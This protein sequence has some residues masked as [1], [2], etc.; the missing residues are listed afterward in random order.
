MVT[1]SIE[2]TTIKSSFLSSVIVIKANVY[3]Y[4]F[5]YW[6]VKPNTL[7][8][9]NRG[10]F[11]FLSLWLDQPY[12]IIVSI[13]NRDSN[14]LKKMRFPSVMKRKR[15]RKLYGCYD[16]GEQSIDLF[17]EIYVLRLEKDLKF[18]SR[19]S[20]SRWKFDLILYEFMYLY[21]GNGIVLFN[22]ALHHIV[23]NGIFNKNEINSE[24]FDIID[25]IRRMDLYCCLPPTDAIVTLLCWWNRK[26]DEQHSTNYRRMALIFCFKHAPCSS[27]WCFY[28]Y[29]RNSSKQHQTIPL[30][31]HKHKWI[32]VASKQTPDTNMK[33]IIFDLAESEKLSSLPARLVP[34][35]IPY[36]FYVCACIRS[37]LIILDSVQIGNLSNDKLSDP[38]IFV[39]TKTVNQW[40][41]WVIYLLEAILIAVA[42]PVS[43]PSTMHLLR[44]R[45][46]PHSASQPM[47]V[48]CCFWFCYYFSFVNDLESTI[49]KRNECEKEQ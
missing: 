33:W 41:I 3:R 36:L 31:L 13:K 14:F 37:S 12:I 30:N 18:S 6:M 7:N 20:W 48:C 29:S 24:S 26:R 5:F 46:L 19:K 34:S 16:L 32:A 2:S 45:S 27:P 39:Y 15:E 28:F 4:S 40:I 23:S 17:H 10:F 25:V 44:P 9:F 1:L 22:K 47:R 49:N 42:A 8:R 43:S 11:P 38:S 21:A 35:I